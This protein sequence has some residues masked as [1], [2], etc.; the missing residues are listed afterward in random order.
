MFC[1]SAIASPV[2]VRD[3]LF[4]VWRYDGAVRSRI[5]LSFRG[6]RLEGYRT[7]SRISGFGKRP[8]GVYTCSV[9]TMSGQVLGSRKLT[10]VSPRG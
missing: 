1:A 8:S 7:Y 3:R 4:H 5:E 2:G 10:I 9:E 6:G